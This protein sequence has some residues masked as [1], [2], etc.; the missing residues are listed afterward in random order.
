MIANG[1]I[2]LIFFHFAVGNYLFAKAINSQVLTL[3]NYM[4]LTIY[5]F[6]KF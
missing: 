4:F 2:W 5:L 6:D 3:Q 1:K